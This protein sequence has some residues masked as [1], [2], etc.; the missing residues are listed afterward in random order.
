MNVNTICSCGKLK[1][2]NERCSC[3]NVRSKKDKDRNTVL[4]TRRWRK[5]RLNIIKRDNYHC[6]R[7]FIKYGVINSE[8]NQLQVHHIKPRIKYPELVFEETNCVTLC[9]RCNLELGT[10]EHLDFDYE[11]QPFESN[12]VL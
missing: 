9:K 5:L 6:Q 4:T 2:A 8:G 11:P 12:Y 10:K 7:C 3:K 1:R